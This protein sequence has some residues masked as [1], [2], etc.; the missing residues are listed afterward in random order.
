[1]LPGAE[2]VEREGGEVGKGGNGL[3]ELGEGRE[4]IHGKGGEVA[5]AG[6]LSSNAHGVGETRTCDPGTGVDE[7]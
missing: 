3:E 1:M 4:V 5:E 6:K 7:G 2:V